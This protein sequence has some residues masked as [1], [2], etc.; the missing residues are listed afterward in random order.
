D[1]LADL[2]RVLPPPVRR[3]ARRHAAHR[4]E[5]RPV[6]APDRRPPDRDRPDRD[7]PPEP[8]RRLPPGA[9]DRDRGRALRG[10]AVRPPRRLPPPRELQV[11]LRADGD[12]A[13]RPAWP[14]GA[15][16]AGERRTALGPLRAAPVPARRA[17]EDHA[18]R[19]PR[20]LPAREPR[21]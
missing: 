15:R 9:L 12:R 17:R 1:G 6:P 5:R 19:L 8:R 11:P 10:P 14:A 2:R 3:R 21:A 20:P 4:A 13:P 16:D 18:D 7:L